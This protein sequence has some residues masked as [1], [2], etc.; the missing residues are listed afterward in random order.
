M[1]NKTNNPGSNFVNTIISTSGSTLLSAGTAPFTATYKPDAVG[2]TFTA[3]GFT[4]PGGPVGYVPN[5]TLASDLYPNPNGVWSVGI[6]DAGAPD[7]GVL[8]NWSID[9]DYVCGVP[10]TPAVWTPA[11]GLF[12]DAVGTPYVA[13]TAVDS[14][15]T[16]PTP[17]GV[18]TYQATVQSLPPAP[19]APATPMA[20]GNGNNM[21]FFNIT[22]NNGFTYNI[23]G[24]ATNAFAAGTA[25]VNLYRKT[26]P[27]AGNPGLINA[28]NG[29]VLVGTAANV[30]VNA[31]VSN[32]VL[33]GLNVA[34]PAGQ[35]YGLGLEF[36]S[37]TT[38]PAYT[39][40][41]GTV[42]TYTD[43]GITISVDGNIGWGGPVAPGPPANNPRNFNGTVFLSASGVAPCTSPART[44][45]VT[46]NTQAVISA[47]PVSTAIC[48]DKVASFS[49][50]ATIALGTIA[51]QWE[52]STDNGNTYNAVSNNTIYSGATTP[53]LTI[54]RPP[55]SMNGYYF[56]C[57]LQGPAPCAPVYS[58]FRILTVYPL[59]TIVI[60]AA[61]YTKLFPGLST[62][63][64]STVS[65]F[66][67]AT[68]TWLRNGIAVSGATS[69]SLNVD[70][71]GLGDY[72]LKVTDVNGCTNTSNLVSIT[73]SATGTLY[74]YPNPNS[75]VFQVRYYSVANNV[76]P[77][78]L[79]IYD[80]KGAR[81]AVQNFTITAPYS[82]MDV[83]LRRYGKGVYWIE[84]GDLNGNRLAVG[85]AVVQ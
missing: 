45:V 42:Q 39:N 67:A 28:G 54:T 69:Q 58:F 72:T 79:T 32:L 16:R 56:R 70:V 31:N 76:L 78:G 73:D 82:R 52:V 60:T 71:D 43:N 83:D 57:K 38:F 62:T 6:Y 29:W 20:G 66:A 64:S 84:L 8:N 49:V 2:A 59:P 37:G 9:F 53:T 80:A 55:V 12:S 75:G 5:T 74:I 50:S 68:Y 3:F 63:L 46:V 25:T 85:R 19:A 23:N 24:I 13:G 40:G 44:V 1:L 81:I 18:Y 34:V 17:A 65:P 47:Q 33:T 10:A 7:A 41:S 51:Y 48:T 30:A 36:I 4:F 26:S 35:T 11:A 61:P 21:V 15:W 77:R 14:V 27:I 22:N